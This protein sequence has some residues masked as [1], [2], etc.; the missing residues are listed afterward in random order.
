MI[1]L[2]AQVRNA[3]L[4]SKNFEDLTKDIPDV[5]KSRFWGRIEKARKVLANYP[6][7]YAGK[8]KHEW[9]SEKQRKYVMWA[10]RQGI[11]KVPYKRSG[12]YGQKWEIVKLENGYMLKN[13]YAAA[14]WIAGTAR[15]EPQARIHQTRWAA[16]RPTVEDVMQELPKEVQK[17]ITMVARKRGF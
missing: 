15:G 8:P 6:S 7:K 4:V 1:Q 13:T 3:N 16:M 9:V 17:H 12:R 10:I 14:R 2:S 11:I 5:S